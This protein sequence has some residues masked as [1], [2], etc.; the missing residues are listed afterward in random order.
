MKILVKQ[1]AAGESLEFAVEVREAGSSSEHRVTLPAA[2]LVT[3]AVV[4]DEAPM[5]NSPLP[6]ATRSRR[7]GVR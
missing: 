3:R 6:L 2:T 5:R 7:G 1:T 4:C